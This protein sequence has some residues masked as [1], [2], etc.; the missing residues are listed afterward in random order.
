M[1][2]AAVYI[3]EDDIDEAP[4]L[5]SDLIARRNALSLRVEELVPVLRVDLR[6]Y[7]SRETGALEVGPELV[8]ELIAME[9]FVADEAA[10]I[11]A[12]A[13]TDGTV[14]LRAVVDQEEFEDAHPDARTLRDLV[15]Y[16]LSLQHVAVGRAAGKLSRQGRAVEVYRG[17]QRGDLTVRRLAA[18]L[19]KEETARLLGIDAKRYAKFERNTAPP[20]AGLVAELQAVDD[21]IAASMTQLEIVEIGGVSVVLMLDDQ[22]AFEKAYPQARTKRDGTVY[23]RRVHRVAAARRAHELEAGG[24]SA[25]IAVTER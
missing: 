22:G 14:V 1:L 8:E 10:R 15:A 23:P 6:K 25:R 9:D 18:G 21:F 2:P 16:P 7:R 5:W 11:I 19:L 4:Y 12:T 20:P 3:R 17:E 13:P 24:R